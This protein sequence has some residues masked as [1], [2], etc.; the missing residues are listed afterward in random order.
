M[1]VIDGRVLNL[2]SDSREVIASDQKRLIVNYYAKYQIKDPVQF[3]RSAKT[4][5]N[6]ENRLRPKKQK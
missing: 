1:L 6:L 5:Y 4:I 3:Y 2:S